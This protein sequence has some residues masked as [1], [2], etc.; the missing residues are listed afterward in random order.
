[1][2]GAVSGWTIAPL[3]LL[4]CGGG[5]IVG[6]LLAKTYIWLTQRIDD[7]PVSVIL[8]FIGTFA[9]WLIADRLGLS[10]ILTVIAYAMTLAQRTGG[11]GARRRISS[12]TV[13][14]VV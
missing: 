10:A 3:F 11:V 6:M 5:V 9:V 8:Q 12:F 2:T 7:I 4:T 13:W 1:T 14:E